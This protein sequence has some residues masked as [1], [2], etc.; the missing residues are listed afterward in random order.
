MFT[1][2]NNAIS[3]IKLLSMLKEIKNKLI[4]LLKMKIIKRW[5]SNI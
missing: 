5:S 1:F 4:N 2:K 3:E